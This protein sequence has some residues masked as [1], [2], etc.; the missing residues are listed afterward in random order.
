MAHRLLGLQ[1]WQTLTK[2]YRRSEAARRAWAIMSP[3]MSGHEPGQVTGERVLIRFNIAF[4]SD[5]APQTAVWIE[6]AGGNFVKTLY[7]SGF[8]GKAKEKQIVLPAWAGKSKFQDNNT[9][10]ASISYGLHQFV[11]DCT[12]GAGTR[13]VNATYTVK[14]EVHHWPSMHYQVVAVDIKVG[15]EAETKVAEEGDLVPFMEVR[16][17]PE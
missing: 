1:Y 8:S 7:V 16:Y 3:A 4:Q 12:N 14:A 5:I 17:I 13:V 2:D 9:T 10:G 6:D 11:W 15:G